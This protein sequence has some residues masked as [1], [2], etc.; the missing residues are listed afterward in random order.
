MSK[1]W[2]DWRILERG[3]RFLRKKNTGNWSAQVVVVLF[4][5]LTDGDGNTEGEADEEQAVAS[6]GPKEPLGTDSAPED[7][8]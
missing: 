4:L 5:L 3:K 8:R 7:E 6:V 1:G 2:V